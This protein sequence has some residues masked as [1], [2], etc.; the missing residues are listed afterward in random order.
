MG[1]EYIRIGTDSG[2]VVEINLKQPGYKKP[3]NVSVVISTP[4][5][6]EHKID[7]PKEVSEFLK[8][9]IGEIIQ[10]ADKMVADTREEARRNRKVP[11]MEESSDLQRIRHLEI[12]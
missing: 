1:S 10:I 11:S 4:T 12:D 9:S 2:G 6:A 7:H 3:G 5:G 8:V